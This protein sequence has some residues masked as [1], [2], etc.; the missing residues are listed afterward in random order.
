MGHKRSQ[1]RGAY[2]EYLNENVVAVSTATQDN[3][4][5]QTPPVELTPEDAASVDFVGVS[6]LVGLM[7]E[8]V[9]IARGDP[10]EGRD[11]G[12]T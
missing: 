5:L 3:V 2:L 11:T 10:T 8:Q 7:F 4:D 6:R 12:T 1:R 9:E